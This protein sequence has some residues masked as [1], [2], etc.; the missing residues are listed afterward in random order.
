MKKP[1][2]IL[3]MQ[4][5]GDLIL[6]YPLMIWLAREYPGHRIFVA[7]EESF[8]KPLM[9][10]SP[11]V[12]YFPWSGTNVLKQ[13]DYD[14]VIN[15]SIQ[16]KAA[17][18]AHEIKAEQKLGPVQA[19]DGSRFVFG[20]WQLYRTSLVKN[21]LYN[22][23]HWA[24]LNALD[25][26]PF[27][28]IAK[29]QF[30]I[31]RTLEP[32]ANKVGIFI[33]ASEEGKRPSAKFQAGLIRELL[34]RGLRPVLCGGPAEV[35]LG[36]EIMKL[37]D[38]PAL[39]LCGK[40]GLDEFGAIG[41]SFALFITPDTGPMHL[42]AWTGLKCLNLSMGHVN[43]W[44]TGPYQPGHFVLRANM[45]CAKGCWRCT[46]SRP[47]C[48]DPFVPARIASLAKRI[49]RGDSSDKLGELQLPGLG[50]TV[51]GKQNG[52]YHLNRID[53]TAPDEERLLSRFWQ[54]FFGTRFNAWGQD[55]PAAAWQDVANNMPE[56][57]ESLI[58]HIPHISR[59]FTRGLK[60]GQLH[61][62]TFWTNSPTVVKP[63]T[64]FVHMALENGNYARTAWVSAIGHL[65]TL[66]S[67]CR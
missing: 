28:S 31:P 13:H 19:E 12:T 58:N 65:E 57:A 5:M 24:D 36:K 14:L 26:I 27:S 34:G 33:G 45:E 37:A 35:E 59:Q 44:E 2:L 18:L 16:E 43:P 1:I 52:L 23:Y 11:A 64:G 17:R 55:L 47:H 29:T 7:A 53:R 32:S 49:V 41:Q 63:F 6:S 3:Q 39:N 50:L 56:V 20:D 30:D 66:I 51:T 25:V 9:N 15:L 61:D 40:L 38:A 60:T 62:E 54:A 8:Y 21:N 48:H 42:A 67:S 46:R 4:R 10:I 22:R